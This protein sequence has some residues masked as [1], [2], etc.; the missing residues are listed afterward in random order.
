MKKLNRRYKDHD[1]CSIVGVRTIVSQINSYVIETNNRLKEIQTEC[2][3]EDNFNPENLYMPIIF[4]CDSSVDIIQHKLDLL[5]SSLDRYLF[6]DEDF[7]PSSVKH[8]KL[9]KIKR[10]QPHHKFRRNDV[11]ANQ[12]PQKLEMQPNMEVGDG[13]DLQY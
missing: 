2:E 5:K 10:L 1:I 9:I 8:D 13:S 11:K 6:A 12:F 4:I 3:H 7:K